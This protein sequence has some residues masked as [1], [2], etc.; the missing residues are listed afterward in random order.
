MQTLGQTIIEILRRK[1]ISPG[2][3]LV[4]ADVLAIVCGETA[5]MAATPLGAMQIPDM[6][7]DA[8]DEVRKHG[9]RKAKT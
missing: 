4:V 8:A 9:K 2:G 1:D 5:G 3:H 6:I 7:Q